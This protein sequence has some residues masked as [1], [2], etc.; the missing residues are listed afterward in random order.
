MRKNKSSNPTS[1]YGGRR[2]PFKAIGTAIKQL[3]GLAL[4]VIA[5]WFIGNEVWQYLKVRDNF[6]QGTKIGQVEVGALGF[7]DAKAK[8]VAH[9]QKPIV[10]MHGQQAVEIF[11]ADA[12]FTLSIDPMLEAA[13]TQLQETPHWQRFANNLSDKYLADNIQPEMGQIDIPLQAAVDEA[14]LDM[15]MGYLANL[16]DRP[17]K[18][19]VL[20]TNSGGAVE[21]GQ[22]GF[23]I[24]VESSRAKVKAALLESENRTIELEILT[25]DAPQID[26][27]YLENYLNQQL[28]IFDGTGSLYVLNLQTGEEL[29]INADDAISGLSVVKV[30]IMLETFRAIDGPLDFDANKLLEETAINS[31]NYSANLLLDIVAGENNAYL[32]VDV[33]TNSMKQLG[34]NSTFI[35]TPYEEPPRSSKPTLITQ[36]NS[37]PSIDF[38]PDPA[39]QTTATEIGRLFGMIYECSKGGGTLIAVYPGKVT[40]EECEALI[41]LMTRNV[42]GNLIRFGVPEDVPVA[43]K[44]G[45]A[46][47]THGD[48]GIVLSPGGDYVI[49]QY[50]HQDTE[51]LPANISFPILREISRSVYNYFNPDNP[52][53]DHKRAQKAAG[54]YAVDLAIQEAEKR[55]QNGE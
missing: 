52:Y 10:A 4:A 49:A 51:W 41:Q 40:P 13:I 37:N 32:G 17:A 2:F 47:N 33:L 22:P 54:V 8:V 35:V 34:L 28:E 26:F 53:V 25:Q 46:Y 43:H 9:Y 31:G 3:S 38:D 24:D 18:P 15:A 23:Q 14:M 27:S 55:Y 11:P 1:L 50:L 21:D 5:L 19:P 6:P 7:D 20:L 44:H 12:G 42:D 45:W 48:V 29:R 16:I 39:M 36:A 30:A